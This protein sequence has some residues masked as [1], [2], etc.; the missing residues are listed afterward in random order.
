MK[1]E[2]C[3]MWAAVFFRLSCGVGIG[4]RYKAVESD[5][6]KLSN[7]LCL[8]NSRRAFAP[9]RDC[10]VADSGFSFELGN[11]YAPLATKGF[12]AFKHVYISFISEILEKSLDKD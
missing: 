5:T 2:R 7:S 4:A 12:D 3:K 1:N 6:E 10:T 9:T 8:I 11:R